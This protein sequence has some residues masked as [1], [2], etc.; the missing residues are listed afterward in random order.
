MTP[1]SDYHLT[2]VVMALAGL[3]LVLQ[4]IVADLTAIRR[5]HKAPLTAANS[6]SARGR[7][8][9]NTNESTAA[10]ALL[11]LAA[12]LTT[13]SPGWTNSVSAIGHG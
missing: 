7:A 3:M 12:M 2:I 6:C 8:H 13:A 11:E 1:L 5:R 4:L 9:A 10:F